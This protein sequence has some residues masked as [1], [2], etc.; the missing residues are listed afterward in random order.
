MTYL[1]I[2]L[3][4]GLILASGVYYTDIRYNTMNQEDWRIFLIVLFLYPL[5]FLMG[6]LILIQTNIEK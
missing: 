5:A 3:L 6:I 1:I 2:Y 4:I